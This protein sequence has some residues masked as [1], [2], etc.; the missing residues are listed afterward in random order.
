MDSR[1]FRRHLSLAWQALSATPKAPHVHEH[2]TYSE[3]ELLS[4]ADEF[5]R[6]AEKHWRSIS[7]EPDA[8]LH[9]LNKPL[10]TVRDTPGILYRLG[11]VLHELDLGVGM[12]VVDF[13]SGSCWL[14]SMINRLRCR[15]I[16]VDVSE[17]ALSFGRLMFE[18]D[19]R[20]Q[21][22]LN[23]RFLKYSGH[24]LDIPSETV[25]RIVCFDS[26]HHVPNQTEV[27]REF[28]RILRPGGR[29]VMGEPGEGHAHSDQGAYETEIHGV[30]ENDIHL[31][32]LVKI[33][34]SVGFHSPQL[35]PFPDPGALTFTL[36]QNTKFMD[37]DDNIFPVDTVRESLRHFMILSLFK[38]K[39]T[40]DSRNPS[41]LR[42][43][44]K[45]LA[46]TPRPAGDG[47][48]QTVRITNTGDTLW[49]RAETPLGGFV[50]LGAH[51][52][53]LKRETVAR[54]FVRVYLPKNVAP[55]ES[56]EM[57]I[58]LPKVSAEG[59]S[60]IQLDMVDDRVAW[61]EQTGS[62][63]L[64][65]TDR[66]EL[67]T[68]DAP[69]YL[70]ANLNLVKPDASTP[71][72]PLSPGQGIDVTLQIHNAGDTRWIAGPAGVRGHVCVGVVICNDA[73]EVLVRDHERFELPKDM[74]PVERTELRFTCHAPKA[75]GKYRLR[76]DLV[77]EGISWFESFGM[78]T[79][80]LKVEVAS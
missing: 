32:D 64:L 13:G 62:P 54:G 58:R 47:S 29:L 21:M 26:F 50:V 6:N 73:G 16:S 36:E 27:L 18:S 77:D 60:L 38:G 40:P 37:G 39:G 34:A 28:F 61:F 20:H 72:P 1:A 63:T 53:N 70:F 24:D 75:P 33:A 12:T 7:Q 35:K 79:V 10:S 52:L 74:N 51:L 3:A 80:D 76:F 30:L 11:L 57:E 45:A 43:E 2:P 59:E 49:L 14:S 66:F 65:L 25:D 23:P 48:I 68:S 78:R 71:L 19:P 5:N 55:Q 4:R 15:T 41:V 9:V 69:G 8:R 67:L 56:I 22:G 17:T 46:L 31:E 44:I 42:A